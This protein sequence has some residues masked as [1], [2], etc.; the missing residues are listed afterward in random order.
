[1]LGAR[2]NRTAVSGS[3]ILPTTDRPNSSQT[4]GW[5]VSRSSS[6]QQ[7]GTPLLR[8]A[9]Y[10]RRRFDRGLLR[11]RCRRNPERHA[12]AFPYSH[13]VRLH[14]AT[15]HQVAPAH[16]QLCSCLG[17]ATG[18]CRARR[19]CAAGA[20]T[21]ALARALA[22]DIVSS[23]PLSGPAPSPWVAEWLIIG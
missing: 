16:S 13:G 1:V 3:R 4:W 15:Q 14:G 22:A 8:Y 7:E 23:P 20:H 21:P 19:G 18:C 5:P 12:A 9:G 11:G 6:G 17:G 10:C 2:L